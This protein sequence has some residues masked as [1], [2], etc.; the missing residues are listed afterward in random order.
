MKRNSRC[1]LVDW[2]AICG[3]A[4]AKR[5]LILRENGSGMFTCPMKYCL[6]EDF[7][8]N[9][10]LRKHI[11]MKHPWYYYFDRQPEVKR[12]EIEHILP[13]RKKVCTSKKPAFSLDEG[14]GQSFFIWLSTTCGG[15]KNSKEATQ[16]AKRAMKFFFEAL[17]NNEC[18]KELT[19]E[20]VDC[21]LGSPSI[22]INFL[23]TLESDWKL[24]SSASLNYIKSIGD[25]LDFRK[26]QGVS[27][28]DLRCFKTAS[29]FIFDTLIFTDDVLEIIN[30]YLE[31]VRPRLQ[32][33]CDYLLI[34]TNGT[35]YQ[36]L[37]SAMVMLVY[38]AIGKNIN[39]TRYRQI[40]ETESSDRLSV[41]EQRIISED[42]KH[43]SRVAK[44]YYKKKQSR[45]VALEGKKCMEKM[46][47]TA[48]EEKDMMNMYRNIATEF[49][50]T[51]MF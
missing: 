24:S 17:G 14:I 47:E 44:V 50:P 21:C 6:H 25:V 20:Y 27:D 49:D 16:I 1:L 18:D 12:E 51:L 13:P 11:D 43:S 26:S 40:I 39:P 37:T 19:N 28:D 31:Y 23:H 29:T 42:Q 7:K 2:K 5:R 10:G 33:K 22:L 41:E 45:L 34:N 30:L 9:R 48:R 15:G 38:Q 32:P 35:Q 36:S 8:S 4:H 46:T 3:A